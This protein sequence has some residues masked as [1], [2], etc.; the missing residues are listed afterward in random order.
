MLTDQV[1]LDLKRKLLTDLESGDLTVRNEASLRLARYASD[2][3]A[4]R[5]ALLAL[6]ED[7]SPSRRM[8]VQAIGLIRGKGLAAKWITVIVAASNDETLIYYGLEVLRRINST[9]SLWTAKMHLEDS[10]PSVRFAA[11]TY[12]YGALG[13]NTQVLEALDSL[14]S[15]IAVLTDDWA[16][17]YMGS[18]AYF[19]GKAFVQG[20]FVA[21]RNQESI[22][23]IDECPPISR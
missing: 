3:E 1:L 22:A 4:R 10:R 17:R 12:L 9:R 20:V 16:T 21:M 18:G 23:Y 7:N 11:L 5:I 14:D 8:L 19:K 13:L 15:D 2:V 6:S